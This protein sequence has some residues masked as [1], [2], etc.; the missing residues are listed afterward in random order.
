MIG[1]N[2]DDDYKLEAINRH[3][4]ADFEDED[5]E[6]DEDEADNEE[7][8]GDG[9]KEDVESVDTG[10]NSSNGKKKDNLKKKGNNSRGKT[11]S[12]EVEKEEDEAMIADE[13]AVTEEVLLTAK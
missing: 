8:S 7:K 12:S 11:L 4:E 6:E 9:D 5:E 2:S 13:N 3:K 10:K 1:I